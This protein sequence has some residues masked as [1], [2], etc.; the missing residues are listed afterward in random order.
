[1]TIALIM[2]AALLM[3]VGLAGAIL[4]IPGIPIMFNGKARRPYGYRAWLESR[5][6]SVTMHQP[7]VSATSLGRDR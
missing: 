3:L 2:L 4:A 7:F 5:Q 6:L 1:M